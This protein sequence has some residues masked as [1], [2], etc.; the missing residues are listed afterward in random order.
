MLGSKSSLVAIWLLAPLSTALLVAPNSPCGQN[1]GNVLVEPT[2]ADIV[3]DESHFTST[4]AGSVFQ[5]CITC[6]VGSSYSTGNQ[7][8]VEWLLCERLR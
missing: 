3:C 8:D 4:T 1:C 7:T 6:E 5:T 2:G